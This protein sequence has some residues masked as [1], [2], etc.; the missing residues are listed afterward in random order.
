MRAS[1]EEE[2]ENVDFQLQE[3]NLKEEKEIILPNIEINEEELERI[4]KMK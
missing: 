3:L 1:L 4:E 2:F